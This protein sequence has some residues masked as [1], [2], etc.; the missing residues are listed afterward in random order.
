MIIKKNCSLL[1]LNYFKVDYNA[2]A[3]I[4][5]ENKNELLFLYSNHFFKGKYLFMGDGSNILF[6]SDFKGTIFNINIKGIQYCI[7][8][9][10]IYLNINSGEKLNEIVNL[11]ISKKYYG[12]E[13]LIL[14][15]GTVGAA[16]VQNIGAYGISLDSVIQKVEVFDVKNG[17]FKV[18]SKKECL[19][20][21]RDSLFKRKQYNNQYIITMIMI[22]LSKIQ[23]INTNYKSIKKY[24]K[25]YN[26]FNPTIKDIGN[27]ITNIRL[28]I[29]PNTTILGTAGSFFKNPLIDYK[30][31]LLLK[32]NYPDIKGLYYKNNKVKISAA[33][34][35]DKCN[36]KKKIID[37]I[38]IW[39]KHSLI[40]VNYG[41]TKGINIYKYSKYISSAVYDKFGIKLNNEVVII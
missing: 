30:K 31:Y 4:I 35:I 5:V 7:D 26:I 2:S 16:P 3:Y 22:K 33:Q 32:N 29:L 37:N 20:G 27:I 9:N 8:G 15:P 40:I 23:K 17:V 39:P 18:F 21:Y 12:I 14:I 28:S 13:N 25:N 6:T 34:L 38:G 36:L 10:S 19:F 11:C 24:I 1:K 41:N